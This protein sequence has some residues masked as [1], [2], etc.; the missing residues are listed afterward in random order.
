MLDWI[1]NLTKSAA[2]KQQE[3][4]T[5]YV[6]DELTPAERQ[7]FE[8]LM[9]KDEALQAE[10]ER[11]RLF[12]RALQ[13]LPRVA[14]PRNFILN[15]ADYRA[16][17][18]QRA[19]QLYPALRAATALAAL[20]LVVLIALP[21]FS[22][23]GGLSETAA[24]IA[25][26]PAES[27]EQ[28]TQRLDATAAVVVTRVVV[29]A[30]AEAVESPAGADTAN[31]AEPAEDGATDEFFEAAPE[32]AEEVTDEELAAEAEEVAAEESTVE[33]SAEEEAD[34]AESEAGEATAGAAA[35][36]GEA[37]PPRPVPT[38]TDEPRAEL[39][40]PTTVAVAPEQ[41]P[42]VATPTAQ[43]TIADETIA[44]PPDIPWLPISAISLFVIL[45]AA[46]L[47]VR[48]HKNKL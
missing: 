27:E 7:R 11:Q 31:A 12:K 40:E 33:E 6:D 20:F 16:P 14:A 32:A 4:L 44:R 2:E 10:M 21:L 8:Q 30:Q 19:V 1:R 43:I 48:W 17:A 35:D 46:T 9:T 13:E 41:A 39:A 26:A 47:V 45:L 18:P 25:M 28:A 23:G 38:I 5:A 42:V 22:S 34:M 36:T 3:M 37:V 15:P 29:E 24:D